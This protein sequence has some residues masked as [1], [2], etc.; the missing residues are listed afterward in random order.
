MIDY[1][2]DEF[3][4]NDQYL[5]EENYR[6]GND[7]FFM[8][9][10]GD[11]KFIVPYMYTVNNNTYKQAIVRF[12]NHLFD[13]EDGEIDKYL[14]DKKRPKTVKW[15]GRDY[16]VPY[17]LRDKEVEPELIAR[18]WLDKVE[19]KYNMIINAHRELF[20][21]D[22]EVAPV[23]MSKR[24]ANDYAKILE[25]NGLAIVVDKKTPEMIKVSKFLDT[26]GDGVNV[27]KGSVRKKG[28]KLIEKGERKIS[29]V[30]KK[31]GNVIDEIK[32]E[33]VDDIEDVVGGL[34]KGVKKKIVETE[35]GAV[36]KFVTKNYKVALLA[37]ALGIAGGGVGYLAN[38]YDS[39]KDK[40]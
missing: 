1:E 30:L 35:L 7:D 14:H 38:K 12:E 31:A 24:N 2:G 36:K 26:L 10:A 32:E 20:E 8:L 33:V 9:F 29:K 13:V 5:I 39:K 16:I 3:S 17:E 28:E 6:N 4:K 23:M 37:G 22:F 11:K 19:A 25:E 15:D 34:K 40:I 21:N 27:V 18:M